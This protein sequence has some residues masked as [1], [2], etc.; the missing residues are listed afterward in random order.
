MIANFVDYGKTKEREGRWQPSSKSCLPIGGRVNHSRHLSL[1]ISE[2]KTPA[3]QPSLQT[4][5]SLHE[6]PWSKLPTCHVRCAPFG[7]FTQLARGYT[8]FRAWPPQL[9]LAIS[10]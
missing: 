8:L 9:N 5:S 4:D 2:G 7:D 1:E 6:R 10:F 3:R